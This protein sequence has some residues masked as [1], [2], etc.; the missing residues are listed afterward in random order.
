[1]LWVCQLLPF[2]PP[3]HF[4]K[5][6]ATVAGVRKPS[7]VSATLN[8]AGTAARSRVHNLAAFPPSLTSAASDKLERLMGPSEIRLQNTE[9]VG[10][11]TYNDI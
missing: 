2:G 11:P 9:Y 4:R 8:G 1:M 3:N 6:T 7:R 5:E 10:T